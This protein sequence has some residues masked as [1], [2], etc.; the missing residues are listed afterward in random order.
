[1]PR[2]VRHFVFYRDRKK[3]PRGRLS[4]SD[5][6]GWASTNRIA[7]KPVRHKRRARIRT[8]DGG[9]GERLLDHSDLGAAVVGHGRGLAGVVEAVVHVVAPDALPH[10][11]RLVVQPRDALLESRRRGRLGRRRRGH[12]NCEAAAAAVAD[13]ERG[14]AAAG[15]ARGRDDGQAGVEHCRLGHLFCS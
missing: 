10:P 8:W 1:M 2:A 14:A 11:R 6:P 15:R 9:E 7:D 3:G 5:W 12:H 4:S 13:G